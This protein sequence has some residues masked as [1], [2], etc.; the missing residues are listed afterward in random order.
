MQT[1][2]LILQAY[3]QKAKQLAEYT[4][5]PRKVGKKKSVNQDAFFEDHEKD[6]VAVCLNLPRNLGNAMVFKALVVVTS[7]LKWNFW[8]DCAPPLA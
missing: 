2:F 6:G 3:I 8:K 7:P 1:Q 4:F 5:Q